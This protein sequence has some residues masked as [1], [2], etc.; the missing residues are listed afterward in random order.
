MGYSIKAMSEKVG[1]TV[2]TLRYYEK[3]GLLPVIE[4]DENGRRVFKDQ[5]LDWIA[6]ICCLRDTGMPISDIK[7]YVTLCKCGN[8]TINARKQLLTDHKQDIEKKIKLF[9]K[10]SQK[11]DKKIEYYDKIEKVGETDCCNP[12]FKKKS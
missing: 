8:S 3:E 2:Y 9:K 12:Y 4:R 11:I 5:D 7:R 6:L 10:Y 1:L